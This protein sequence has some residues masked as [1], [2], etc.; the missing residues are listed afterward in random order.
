[1][2][3][4]SGDVS[5][6]SWNFAK[7]L[8]AKDGTV[9]ARYTASCKVLLLGMVLL[10]ASPCGECVLLSNLVT[11]YRTLYIP[12][13][14]TT[15]VLLANGGNKTK[16]EHVC[17][18]CISLSLQQQQ[19]QHIKCDKAA[20]IGIWHIHGSTCTTCFVPGTLSYHSS[21]ADT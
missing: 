20:C 5:P 2:Q 19:A 17:P 7:F 6:I 12:L 3:A 1:M 11:L 13:P 14:G 15:M 16:D 4:A 9:F 10:L 21:H 8:V 18:C